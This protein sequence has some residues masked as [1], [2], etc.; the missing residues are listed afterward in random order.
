M[1]SSLFNCFTYHNNNFDQSHLYSIINKPEKNK[2]PLP[3]YPI[4]QN[5]LIE[6]RLNS[7]SNISFLIDSI[8]KLNQKNFKKSNINGIEL[9]NI[10]QAYN[11]IDS[12]LS[13]KLTTNSKEI[14]DENNDIKNT[15]IK[16]TRV[17]FTKEEDEKVKELVQ[18]YGT[19]KWIVVSSFIKGRTAKQCR[20]RY[21]NYLVPGYFMG[22]WSKEEDDLIIKL[23]DEHGPKWSVIQRSLE[24]RSA[25]A[26][27]NRW[28]Y[29]LSR[30]INK[31][32][33]LDQKIERETKYLFADESLSIPSKEIYESISNT[34][35]EN[36][37]F[38]FKNEDRLI[39]N[40]DWI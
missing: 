13:N 8:A 2:L 20:D 29:F 25:N 31:D 16:K 36:N 17:P 30:Q 14:A 9:N 6:S 35:K 15:K 12:Y 19:K 38:D 23:Y 5:S 11:S 24:D 37:I 27:K 32:S 4:N 34:E 40:I 33:E 7:N 3:T 26:I 21:L 22:E 1:E 28:K 18:I 10:L 39:E